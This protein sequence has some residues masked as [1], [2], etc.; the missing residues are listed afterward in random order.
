ML[1]ILFETSPKRSSAALCV[2]FCSA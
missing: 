2:F 1:D